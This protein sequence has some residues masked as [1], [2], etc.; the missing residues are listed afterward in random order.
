MNNHQAYQTLNVNS[1]TSLAD[2]KV[3]YRKL[4]LEL[5]PDKNKEEDEGKELKKITEA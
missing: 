3:S 1:D 2:L 4:A 5:H